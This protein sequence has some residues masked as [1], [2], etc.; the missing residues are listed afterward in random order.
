MNLKRCAALCALLILPF[1]SIRTPAKEPDSLAGSAET[2]PPRP[3]AP[4]WPQEPDSLAESA[5]TATPNSLGPLRLKY[6]RERSA[7]LRSVVA[8]YREE[9]KALQQRLA[10]ESRAV[11]AELRKLDATMASE[12]QPD[13]KWAVTSNGWIWRS[14]VDDAGVVVIFSDDGTVRHHEMHGTWKITGPL[15]I[16][17]NQEEDG[18]IVL[19][20]DEA[21]SKFKGSRQ[22]VTGERFQ[23]GR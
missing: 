17:I 18:P 14:E 11:A 19:R 10:G 4:P 8:S 20:F 6:E 15:E 2:P 21:L 22:A 5:E 12:G 7:A 9:L 23:G 16:T 13:L 3:N 1:A